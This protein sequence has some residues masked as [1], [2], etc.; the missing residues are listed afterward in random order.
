MEVHPS[1]HTVDS[2]E[3]PNSHQGCPETLV[4]NMGFQ[5]PFPPIIM[6]Q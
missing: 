1:S 6:V 5:L 3:I 4:K 2:S